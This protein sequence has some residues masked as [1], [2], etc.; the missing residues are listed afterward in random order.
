MHPI[1]IAMFALMCLALATCCFAHPGTG[2]VIA[3]DGT[4]YFAY[5]PGHRV[6]KVTSDG[7]ASELVIG[8]LDSDFRVPH[9]LWLDARGNL[10]TASDAGSA[11]WRIARDGTKTK[12]YPPAD[13]DGRGAVALGGDPFTLTEDGRIVSIQG[14]QRDG[15]SRIVIIDLAGAVTP[16]AGGQRG[17]ADG[18]GEQ[19][20]FGYLAMASFAWGP[21]GNLYM[22]DEGRAVRRISMKGEVT[23][24][25][26]G[27]E[28]GMRDGKGVAARFEGAAGLAVAPDGTIFVADAAAHRI[29]K[30]APDG[31]VATLAG[32]GQRGGADGPA[33]QATFDEPF[34][35][36][37]AKDG[38][39][40]ILEYAHGSDGEF[41][42]IRRIDAIGSVTTHAVISADRVAG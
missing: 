22:T 18:T 24:I 27:A 26:G 28:T 10:I 16:L 23:T 41:V 2:I 33:M 37:R 21:A 17:F 40:Y 7:T 11:V 39:L 4:I 13:W 29:C 31:T 34:G 20:R 3:D 19:A 32:A 14:A 6:W 30:I 8:S 35:I 5:G 1:R 25:A 42:R 36:T 12:I 9:S 38:T 15:F